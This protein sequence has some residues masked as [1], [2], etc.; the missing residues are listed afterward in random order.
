M[1]TQSSA[2]KNCYALEG[3]VRID[4]EAAPLERHQGRNPLLA[5]CIR[6]SP[7]GMMREWDLFDRGVFK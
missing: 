3:N 1:A 7:R 4:D 6:A 2:K 5:P